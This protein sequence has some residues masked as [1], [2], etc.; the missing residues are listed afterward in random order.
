MIRKCAIS[1]RARLDQISTFLSLVQRTDHGA[2]VLLNCYF[3][4][5]GSP[6]RELFKLQYC[7]LVELR[8]QV[9]EPFCC[10]FW[11]NANMFVFFLSLDVIHETFF[12]WMMIFISSMCFCFLYSCHCLHTSL[13]HSRLLL[14]ICFVF[15]SS[16]CRLFKQLTVRFQLHQ[17]A[18]YS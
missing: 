10:L 12:Y 8:V 18:E 5:A 14:F 15:D 2:F 6:E 16:F 13:H 3:P 9:F 1:V 4:N 11:E 17:N 7:R